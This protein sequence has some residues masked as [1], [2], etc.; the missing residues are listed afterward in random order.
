MGIRALLAL[1]S[2]IVL[3]APSLA[4]LPT[5]IRAEHRAGQTFVTWNELAATGKKYRVYRAEFPLASS[6]DLALAD[7]LGEVDD[8]SSRNQGR[9]LATRVEHTWIIAPGEAPLSMSQGLF[10]HTA[11][12]ASSSAYYAVTSAQSGKENQLLTPGTNATS[13]PLEEIPAL[14]EPVLQQ[15][16][17]AGE[18]WGHWFGNRETPFLPALSLWPSHGYNFRYEPGSGPE[19][20]GL[21]VRLHAAGQTYSQGWPLR[22]EV[23]KD[24]DILALSDLQAF[25]SFSIWFGAHELLPAAP[26][27]T[28]R[29]WN[30]TQQRVLWTLD[31]LTARLGSAHDPARVYAIGGS[32]GAIGAMYLLTEAP[33][34]FAAV[35]CR[36][37]LY[38]V[39]A[40]DFKNP[41]LLQKLWGSFALDL[42]THSGLP[43]TLRTNAVWMSNRD[44]AVEWP[45]VRTINGRNDET[46]GWMS[47]VGLFEGLSAAS[48]PAVHYFDERTHNPN[49]YWKGVQPALLAR[50]FQTRRDRPSLRF[51]GCTLD[52]DPGNG[53][54]LDGDLVGTINGYLDYD[55]TT[56]AATADALDFDVYL[57]DAGT[58]DDA[59]QS[60]GFAALTPRRTAPFALEPGE[61]VH[62][63]LREGGELVDEQLLHADPNGLVH[64]ALVP[65]SVVRR[66]A[67][68]ERLEGAGTA[69][70]VESESGSTPEGA[71]VLAQDVYGLG[72]LSVP[73]EVDYWRVSLSAGTDVEIEVLAARYDPVAW[74]A[75]PPDVRILSADGSVELVRHAALAWPAFLRDLDFPHWLVPADGEYLIALS[76]E[77]RDGGAYALRWKA[78]AADD[79]ALEQ[80]PAGEVGVNDLVE[81]AEPILPGTRIRGWGSAGSHD[82]YSFELLEDSLV[83]IELAQERLG[84]PAGQAAY[85]FASV[86]LWDAS[87]GFVLG[88]QFLGDPGARLLRRAG[89]HFVGVLPGLSDGEYL[90]SLDVQPLAGEGEIEPDDSV[91]EAMPIVPGGAIV[92]MGDLDHYSFT[93][94]AGDLLELELFDSARVD[95]QT[96]DLA[97]FGPL[98]A[99][100][101]L[102]QDLFLGR[103]GALLTETGAHVLAL[104]TVGPYFLRLAGARPAR[105]ESEPNDE[106]TSAD[107]LWSNRAAGRIDASGDV[108]VFAF[109]ARANRLILLKLHGPRAG[110]HDS[111]YGSLLV[112]RL[113]ILD[114]QGN[115]LRGEP[116]AFGSVLAQ[117]VADSRAS[118]TLGFVPTLGGTYFAR[119]EDVAGGGGAEFTY[120]L[121][122]R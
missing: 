83:S 14:P 62:F 32:M 111:G 50:T 33:E 77:G 30:Y 85:P 20:R 11:A 6:E 44:P 46:V 21:L 36:N 76:N 67:R 114:P 10:V 99:G 122:L 81:T 42:P 117:G 19:P 90:L 97:L 3:G 110:S 82:W 105:F 38:D 9:S 103:L 4:Q 58:L 53:D 41:A 69:T 113:S 116:S 48:R 25:T 16:D 91:A 22:F 72:S 96:M 94:Q 28:T 15:K 119:V 112:P 93:G 89:T 49:G 66:H 60:T 79:L 73:G 26:G 23:P 84:I 74:S 88:P 107:P 59:P 102:Q 45:V 95:E 47:A 109:G 121:E 2:L 18:L 12:L 63:T 29:V 35:L 106:P 54:R 80:E 61:P 57:R 101:P 17:G 70:E 100:V 65:L 115:E 37:A 1:G 98:G 5:G 64:T 120:W 108:D 78:R 8:R 75:A 43:I 52:D 7:Y 39:L 87:T 55:P 13:A 27:A 34:R 68:F 51:D 71:T 118:L 104:Q 56:A 86:E 92:G 31:W 40:T 24:V